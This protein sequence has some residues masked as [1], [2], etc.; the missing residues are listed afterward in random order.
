MKP[1]FQ[2]L[3]NYEICTGC[4]K[5]NAILCLMGHRG[6]QEWTRDKSRVSFENLRKFPFWWAQK[7]IIFV[8]KRLRKMRSKMPTPPGKMAW[9]WITPMMFFFCSYFNEKIYWSSHSNNTIF[10]E[11]YGSHQII[12]FNLLLHWDLKPV[13]IWESLQ[14]RVTGLW[15]KA[16]SELFHNRCFF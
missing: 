12:I 13:V 7:L 6:H 2:S 15:I 11:Y 14:K 9:L 8:K 4:P 10:L 1:R 16:K 5:K 3:S